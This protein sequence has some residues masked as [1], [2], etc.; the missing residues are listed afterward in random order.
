MIER[1]YLDR[2]WL[3][4]G[5]DLVNIPHNVKDIPY[6]YANEDD[7]Q[8]ISTYEKEI[9]IDEKYKNKHLFLNFEGVAHKSDIYL[10]DKHL[11]TNMCGYN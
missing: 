11:Y 4:N 8:M 6:N 1:I 10:N 5:E 3:F 9:I 7:Y 2:N